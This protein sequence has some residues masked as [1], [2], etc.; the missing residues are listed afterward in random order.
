ML[1]L[2]INCEGSNLTGLTG[3]TATQSKRSIAGHMGT[4]IER[5]H[6]PDGPETGKYVFMSLHE[7]EESV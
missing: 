1:Q 5:T 6:G 4:H 7:F 3:F 2:G